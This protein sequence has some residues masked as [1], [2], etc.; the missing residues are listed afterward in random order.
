MPYISR[1][2]LIRL[3]QKELQ[4]PRK[5]R[6]FIPDLPCHVI[7]R[8]NNRSACFFCEEDYKYYLNCIAEG[9]KRYGAKLHAYVLM[10]NHVHLLI[11]PS[12][13]DSLPRIMQLIGRQYVQYIN[14][15]YRR[16]GTLWEGRYKASIVDTDPYL[17]T[18]YRYIELNPVVAGMVSKPEDYIWSSFA[19]NGLGEN[20]DL[21]TPH[22][23]YLSLGGNLDERCD[24]YR[25][26]FNNQIS[27]EDVHLIRKASQRNYPL[28]NDRFKNEIEKTL[29]RRVGF[30][31]R[32]RPKVG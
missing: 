21:I 28:G 4:M 6:I 27:D 23:N 12:H 29:N 9:L 20:D 11:T 31:E 2:K 8:G 14:K 13:E 22:E 26:L 3:T 17:L 16:S 10:M 19:G 5:T 30:L 18:C 32:G 7:Q 1:L 15:T 25:E 24:A